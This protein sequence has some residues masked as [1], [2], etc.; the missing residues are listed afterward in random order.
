MAPTVQVPC[1][2]LA[3][4]GPAPRKNPASGGLA[5]PWA[6]SRRLSSALHHIETFLSARPFER[7][8]WLVVGF[9]LG[10]ALWL[11]LAEPWQ[12]GLLLF[13]CLGVALLSSVIM[14]ADGRF[15]WVRAA[16]IGMAIMTAAGCATVW[17]K[18]S[19]VGAPAITRPMVIWLTGRIE[20]RREQG[21]QGRVRLTLKAYL[22]DGARDADNDKPVRVRLNLDLADDSPLL[23]EG[24]VVRLRARLMPPAAPMLPGAHDFARSAWFSGLAATGSGLGYP[25]IVQ[26]ASGGNRLAQWRRELSQHVR[27]QLAGTPGAIAS[28]FATGDRGAIAEQDEEAMRDAGLTHL[29]SISGLHVSAVVAAGYVLAIRLLALSPWLALRIPLPLAAAASGAMLGVGYTLLTGA[30]VPTIRSCIG[31]LLVLVALAAGRDPLSMRMVAIAAFIV[32]LFWPEALFGPSFQM[33]FSAVIAI[34]ALH[35][36]APIKR[37]LT[38]R[39]ESVIFRAGRQ[40]AMLLLTGF[41]IEIALM[42]IT[43]FHFH[44]TGVYGALANVIAIPLT[45]FATMPLIALAL[46]LD[47]FGVGQPI[48]WAAGKSLELLLWLA[49]T[50]ASQPGAVALFP[51]ISNGTYGLFVLGGLWLALWNGRLRWWGGIP[52][53]IGCALILAHSPPD[54]LISGDGRHVAITGSDGSL[55][56]LREGRG[57]YA[58]SNL[59]EIAGRDGMVRPMEQWAGARCNR[60]FCSLVVDRDGV[61]TTLLVSRGKDRVIW[62]DLVEACAQSDIVIA[63]RRLPKSCHPRW[64]KADRSM[65]SQTGGMAIDLERREIETVAQGQGHHGWF[66]WPN[67][68]RAAHS[69]LR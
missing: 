18:S 60:D 8:N 39:D 23:T 54:I 15:G 3:G 50:T 11:V 59:L 61:Q 51:A 49:H 21:A 27:Q 48:W 67:A 41:V 64:I 31:A 55:L 68:E 1:E 19:L 33:S 7:G 16:L 25:E 32:L 17:T 42:P 9:A 69:S 2:T 47:L 13:A 6:I 45:T 65:L 43:L 36:A 10:I 12:W 22:P 56:V 29:L 4:A 66:R 35:G 28:A 38:P 52:A 58:R 63:D 5:A 37:F 34:V 20:Q 62:Q 46:F 53:F 14:A 40:L 30:D 57:D 26:A 24:A 44:R